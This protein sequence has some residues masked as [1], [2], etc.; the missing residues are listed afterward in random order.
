MS[1][2]MTFVEMLQKIEGKINWKVA[3]NNN[4]K[5]IYRQHQDTYWEEINEEQAKMEIREHFRYAT[6]STVASLVKAL[7]EDA[8][9]LFDDGLFLESRKTTVGF[10]NG[11]FD[12]S[13][14]AVRR[15]RP[16]DYIVN[17]LPHEID[18]EV[19]TAAERWFHKVLVSWVGKESAGWLLSL[20]AYILFIHPN[21]ENIWV[22]FFG[23]GANGKSVLL[24]LMERILGDDRC[25]GCDLKNINRFSGDAFRDKWLVV[26]RDS[27]HRVSE[28]ATSFI[29]SFSGDPKLTVEIK[30]VRG[31]F[32][33]PNQG[34]LIVSTNALVQSNDRSFGWYR[35]LV[36]IHFP[37]KFKRDKTFKKELFTDVPKIARVL[38]KYAHMYHHTDTSLLASMPTPSLRLVR[39]TRMLND[40]VNAFWEEY[41]HSYPEDDLYDESRRKLE[42]S[43]LAFCDNMTMTDLYNVYKNWHIHEFGEADIQPSL[44]LGPKTPISSTLRKIHLSEEVTTMLHKYRP[45]NSTEG[46]GFQA[47][48][49]RRCMRYPRCMILADTMFYDIRDPKYPTQWQYNAAGRP[50]CTAYQDKPAPSQPP[51]R[52]RETSPN[53]R[54]LSLL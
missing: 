8:D 36:P 18:R 13:T 45:S 25:I 42:W 23:K 24:E 22:N 51:E 52:I 47:R 7:S 10:L 53:V 37:N 54:Q 50:V 29:K 15:Y 16:S 43:T 6:P 4:A 27:S 46:D 12:L 5:M 30:G 34:K 11:V 1:E 9:R 49:C 33:T 3:L 14:G 44:T 17:P 2:T 21:S 40:R 41:F 35:R 20:I 32:D 48:W 31:S 38:L 39:E 28:G 19:D 26:G